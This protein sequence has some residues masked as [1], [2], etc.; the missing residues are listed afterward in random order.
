MRHLI[1]STLAA[2]LCG[3]LAAPAAAEFELD[4]YMGA[5]S[6]ASSRAEGDRPGGG[7]YGTTFDWEGRSF[8]MPFYYGLRGTWWRSE[9]FGWGV[10][11]THT[12]VY[13]P[14]DER[15]AAGFD[16]FELSDGH[17]II[18]VNALRRWPDGWQGLTPYVGAGVGFAMPHVDVEPAGGG[19]RTYGFEVT[20]PA[21]RL[22][23]GARYA[24]T[25]RWSVFGEV[26]ATWS[27]N[28]A[29]LDGGGTLET[30]IVTQAVNLGIGYS[31]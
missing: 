10:E 29:D 12:K 28:T 22:F 18:T 13:A 21:A 17:N 15:D 2:V 9:T 24:V 25:E 4:F 30:E 11:G 7:T 26:Q 8:E 23:A 1:A 20:G 16:R 5:Q 14:R 3:G 19:P 27:D 6:A 31:F